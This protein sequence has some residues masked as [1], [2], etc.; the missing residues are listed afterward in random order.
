VRVAS[1]ESG[2]LWN[3]KL[4][5]SLEIGDKA[6]QLGPRDLGGTKPKQLL[7]LLLLD[8]GHIVSKDRLA[9]LLWGEKPP[10]NAPGAL[11]NYISVLRR[12]LVDD[13][14][15]AQ[16]VIVTEANGYRIDSDHIDVDLDRFDALAE[17]A[18]HAATGQARRH[19]REAISLADR[20]EVLEDEPYAN[21]VM[22]LRATYSAR[23]VGVALDAAEAALAEHDFRP[24][25]EYAERAIAADRHA[26]RGYRLAMLALYALERQHDAL[27]AHRRLRLLLRDDLGLE[28][29]AA[30]NE[31]QAAILSHK[32]IGPLLP[33]PARASV[34]AAE[35]VDPPLIGRA[36]ELASLQTAVEDTLNG[37]SALILVEGETGV[38]KSRLLEELVSRLP[39]TRVGRGTGSVLDRD[40]H[41]VVLGL[42]LRDVAHD[43]PPQSSDYPALYV[44]LPEL[45]RPAAERGPSDADVFE[46]VVALLRDHAPVV[47][48]I[49]D[50]HWADDKTIAAI[51]YLM[52]RN[53]APLAIVGAVLPQQLSFEH[54]LRRLDTTV[55]ARLMPLEPHD[56]NQLG[57]PDLYERTGGHPAFV[58]AELAEDRQARQ[59][60]ALEDIL[61]S[62]C[63]AE[64]AFTY[65][66]LLAASVLNA[67]FDSDVLAFVVRRDPD[68][69]IEEL[70][71][72][73]D[74]RILE[75]EG[76]S[77]RFRYPVIADMLRD[78]LTP[79]RR[80]LL[81]RRADDAAQPSSADAAGSET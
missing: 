26:E 81:E 76:M 52:R 67:S 70:E 14:E 35:H 79:A 73:C 42:V 7:E 21:W 77:F 27:G 20:G 60:L 28:P 78:T 46:S 36:Q 3:V 47:L 55:G 16:R 17:R 45:E 65:T 30:T 32:D 18:A 62:C 63:R 5:G 29:S 23:L 71:R 40:M 43:A 59:S 34:Q 50:L 51:G 66:L 61:N 69:V 31:L 80:D 48:V 54:P 56:L 64:G 41:Y 44:V 4:F 12:H 2:E 33:R 24:A 11:E 9:D 10:R 75:A 74:R 8:R 38:G 25:L 13:T 57:I 68:T 58:A 49:D 39:G 19:L 15:R 53:A 22:A 37:S 1:N 6:R 72:L